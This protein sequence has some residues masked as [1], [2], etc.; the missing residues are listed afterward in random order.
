MLGLDFWSPELQENHVMLSRSVCDTLP[1]QS[2][3]A[4]T[5]KKDEIRVSELAN[6]TNTTE[7]LV[8]E[9]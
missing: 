9:T 6:Y 4:N 1:Q 3:Q 5:H 2:S 8:I 7:N